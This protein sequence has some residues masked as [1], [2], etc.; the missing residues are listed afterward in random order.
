VEPELP[1]I[2]IAFHEQADR[3]PDAICIIDGAP[4][5][6]SPRHLTYAQAQHRVLALAAELRQLSD[7]CGAGDGRAGGVAA[8]YMEPCPDYIVSMLA[9]LTAGM[10]Y[11]PL[12]L[13][14]PVTM[15]QRVLQDASP[16]AILTHANLKTN[17]PLANNTAV[18]ICLDDAEHRIIEDLP[19]F[20]EL[21]D[22]LSAGKLGA[23]TLDDMAFIVYSSGTT[24][25]PKG[26]ANPHRAPAISYQWRFTDIVDYKLGD[27]VACNVFFVWEALR[28]IMRGGAVIP[29]PGSVIYDG[30]LLSTFLEDNSVTEM[31]FTPSLMEN[32]FNTV[33]EDK[34][35]ERLSKCLR[36]ILLNGEVVSIALRAM[37]MKM[38]AHVRFVNL[39]SISECHEVGAVDLKDVDLTL[40]TKFCPVGDPVSPVFILDE[41]LQPALP[42]D[43]G[44]LYVGGD[45]LAIGYLGLP[46]LTKQRF[47]PNP[48]YADGG[49]DILY[50]TGDRA[51]IMTNGQLEILGRCDFMVK[52]RGYS[53]VLGAVEAALLEHVALSSCV[54]V[55]DGEEGEDKHLVAYLVRGQSVTAEEGTDENDTRL[56]HFSIDTRT[57]SCPE[58]RR[59][60]DGALPHYMVPHVYIEVASLPV[61]AVGAKLDRKAL[62]AQ[63][64]DRRAMLRSLQFSSE[65][66]STHM[67]GTDMGAENSSTAQ[68]RLRSMAKYLRVPTGTPLEEV[69]YA[70]ATLWELVLDRKAGSLGVDANFLDQGGHSLNAARL[71]AAINRAFDTSLTTVQL[72]QSG[73]TVG[74]IAM[75]VTTSWSGDSDNESR[76]VLSNTS[77]WSVLG[78]EDEKILLQ[79]KEDSVL[80][81]DV[82]VPGGGSVICPL[83]ESKNI[84]LTGATGFLGVHVL[85][86]ILVRHPQALVTCM[87]RSEDNPLSK[88]HNNMELYGLTSEKYDYTRIRTVKGDLSKPKLGM[89]PLEWDQTSSSVDAIIH[90]GAAVSLT[91]SYQKLHSTNV[92]GTLSIIRLACNSSRRIPLVYVSTN[93]IFPTD[94]GTEEIFMENDDIGCLPSRLGASD[95]Y[96]LSKWVAERLVTQAHARGLPT[97][98]VRFGNIGWQSATG[99]GNVWDYQGMMLRGCGQMGVRPQCWKQL[100]MSPIDFCAG[101]LVALGGSNKLLLEGSIFNCVQNG[102][103][104]SEQVFGWMEEH[105]NGGILTREVP[106]EVWKKRLEVSAVDGDT[107]IA[108]LLAFAAGLVDG[109]AYL[110]KMAVLDCSKFDAALAAVDP[111]LKR[112]SLLEMKQYYEAFMRSNILPGSPNASLAVP[113]DPTA[114]GGPSGPLAGKVAVVTGASSGIGRAIV[115]ALVKAGCHVAM[116]A[117]NVVNLKKTRDMVS[118]ECQGSSSKTAIVKTDVTKREDV[119]ALV[120]TAEASLGPVNIIVN[121]AGC[122]YFTLM[123]NV[124]WDQWERQVDVNAKGTMYGIGS[125]LPKM[126]ERGQGHIINITSDAGRKSFP[127]LAVYSGTKFFV[128]AI[129]QALRL[130]TASSGLRVTCIQPGNV[131]T[132]LLSTSTDLD[133]IKE[134]GTPSGAKVLEPADIGRA[135]VYAASQ[136]E[137]CA[138]N[139]ILVEPRQEPA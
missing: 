129:S 76:D 20:E 39:Y 68:A 2:H 38:L 134:Y 89:S 106:F 73:A 121:C 4:K 5:N 103:T 13:A 55:A 127:G 8:I 94:K 60:V 123:K 88:V 91:A 7:A 100:E 128:E 71:V 41:E 69:E 133:G 105:G 18:G 19:P 75:A 10:A 47:I 33:P 135:V 79:V 21:L 29:V 132:P 116:G 54:V 104:C 17:L 92:N 77:E 119:E 118:K 35:K 95:G 45:M 53:I 49:G 131:E 56:K 27:V 70:M 86:E 126:L 24:G 36:T 93:G 50:R 31:L 28:P 16:V 96:G 1:C 3:T 57:G 125:V 97:I 22:D 11:L 113:V 109:E 6:G 25:Q 44:E 136:P 114:T 81:Q 120:G 98:T 46:E 43:A 115:L 107:G 137:W 48:F 110:S 42:G 124:M 30:E 72:F 90:C 101:A 51:R 78:F 37:C 26:I 59:A 108:G 64:S 62:Q 74:K 63:A 67:A 61:S 52:I 99:I 112:K 122:M 23:P 82:V 138:V 102:T 130:E 80:P 32:L 14:Y 15:L 84:L 34:L 9:I 66:H 85:A 40:S 83:S 139:E 65:T 117:R 58:I 87:V 12:E 111:S